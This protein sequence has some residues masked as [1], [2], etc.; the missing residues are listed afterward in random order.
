M[1]VFY[2]F[3]IEVC[4]PFVVMTIVMCVIDW[5]VVMFKRIFS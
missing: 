1:E 4:S 2:N 5:I 3:A